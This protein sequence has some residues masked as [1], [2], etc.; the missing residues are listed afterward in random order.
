MNP[1][2]RKVVHWIFLIVTVLL[3]V[4]VYMWCT[5]IKVQEKIDSDTLYD[6]VLFHYGDNYAA[7]L[8]E[9][10][11][12]LYYVYLPSFA[13]LS[14]LE[15]SIE[16]TKT[17]FLTEDDT[18]SVY[19]H[20]KNVCS[21]QPETEYT[22]VFYDQ[23]DNS[24]AEATVV[25]LVSGNLPTV[26]I[27]TESG[28]F[29]EIDDDKEYSEG[30]FFSFVDTK[31]KTLYSNIIAEISARGN[32]TF[33]FEK[34]SYQFD[35]AQECNL[36]GMGESSTWI[37]L[38]NSYDL[39]NVRNKIT[40]DMAL[41]AEMEGSPKSEYVDVFFNDIYHG[42]YLLCEK[43]EFGKNRL[44]YEDMESKN[45][46]LNGSKLNIFEM[47]SVDEGVRK[48]YLLPET[49]KDITG[50]YLLEHDY[51]DKYDEEASGF[52]TADNECY[53][54]KNPKHATPSEVE[55]ISNLF[56]EIEDAIKSEDGYNKITGKHYSEYIDIK[57]WADKYIVEEFCKNHGGG[58]TSSYFY[59]L[60]DEVSTKVFGGPVWD[61]D[62]AY[63]R[64]GGPAGTTNDLNFLTLHSNY[65]NW[66]YYLY[67]QEDFREVVFDEYQNVFAPY[68]E[69][70]ML[71]QIDYYAEI[72]RPSL[73]LNFHRFADM[74][75]EDIEVDTAFYDGDV[76]FVKQYIT[77]RKE[78]LDEMW[79]EEKEVCIVR[80]EGTQEKNRCIAVEKGD[81]LQ[82]VL[83]EWEDDDKS[84]YWINSET[85]EEITVGM[86]IEQDILAE[87]K[88]KE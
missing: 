46:A 39:S 54:I 62:K 30:A 6:S 3:L 4:K 70:V 80:F 8:K 51:G 15:V 75:V 72:L 37:L 60:P 13:D 52:K 29:T 59:K 21:F 26:Y 45:M 44:D 82:I 24:V 88:E 71:P 38:C 41:H 65:T 79:G 28:D 78:T 67:Q 40:Y 32:H 16:N 36:L 2:Q 25:F 58:C 50:G 66:F 10:A 63:G 33:H 23:D 7:P 61:Y 73:K 68:I 47:F 35:L 74:Y 56:Q 17:N 11:D 27:S 83:N 53:V 1:I 20:R 55:Y 76:E 31:G 64:N 69:K 42:T 87:L 34:K 19:N 22:M 85:G 86:V 43:V 84:Y 18:I 5:Q 49:P 9:V 48:G 57:S 81:V 77:A 12:N 14:N